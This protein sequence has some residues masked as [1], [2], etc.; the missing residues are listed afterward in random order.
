M[1][2]DVARFKQFLQCFE[3]ISLVE[4]TILHREEHQNIITYPDDKICFLGRFLSE[5][6]PDSTDSHGLEFM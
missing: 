2:Q 4:P 6:I 3:L 5:D 1:Q